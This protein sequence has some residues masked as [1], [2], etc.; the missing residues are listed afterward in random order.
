M[1]ALGTHLRRWKTAGA[2]AGFTVTAIVAATVPGVALTNAS[3]NATEWDHGAFATEN[4]ATAT[5]FTTRGAGKLIGGTLA[6]TN[7]DNLASL[8]GVT[9]TNGSGGL[10]ATP[11]GSIAVPPTP[12]ATAPTDAF[13]NPLSVSALHSI[14]LSLGSLLQLPEVGANVGALGQYGEAHTN[15]SSVGASGVV[16]NSGAIDLGAPG[17]GTPTFGTLDL[18]SVLH[19]LGLDTVSGLGDVNLTLGAVGSSVQLNGCNAMW[20]K[21]IYTDN[22]LVR[23]YV[24]ASLT[25]NVNSPLVGDIVSSVNSTAANLTSTVGSIAGTSGFVNTAL[26][27]ITSNLGPLLTT[28]GLGTPTATLSASVNFGDLTTL[29]NSSIQDSG[30]IVTI[31]LANGTIAIDTAALFGGANGLNGQ[32][33]NTQLLLNTTVINNLKTAITG[34]LN[35]YVDEVTTAIDNDLDAATVSLHISIP[36][37]VTLPIVG[38]TVGFGITADATNVSLSSLEAGNAPL[39]VTATCSLGPIVCPVPTAALQLL[40]N[41]AS[42]TIASAIEKPLGNGIHGLVDPLVSGLTDTL[43]ATT[44]NIEDLLASVLGGLFGQGSALSLVVNNQNLPAPGSPTPAMG[45]PFPVWASSLTPAS[46]TPYGTGQYDESAI[47]LT[48]LGANVSLDLARSSAG[49]NV[50]TP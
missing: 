20:T 18:Q 33:P 9:V 26:G 19:Q 23:N 40:L 6:G 1:S 45:H 43:N 48:I 25:T 11:A 13:E 31:N 47:E 15:G 7:L 44:G 49:S 39:T 37:T 4:C 3:W 14:N 28:L 32:L 41:G 12:P 16:N 35:N 50:V 27:T 24:I 38:P 17:V 36:A 21:S 29:L 22:N 10:V 2:V 42:A 8:N 46:T 5:N 30:H 34:A